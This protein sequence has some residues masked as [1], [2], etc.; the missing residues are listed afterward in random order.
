MQV[1]YLETLQQLASS[2][3][4]KVCFVPDEKNQEKLMH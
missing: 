2:N 1:R 4:T 3:G